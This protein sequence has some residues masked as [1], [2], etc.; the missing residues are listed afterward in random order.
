LVDAFGHHFN[1]GGLAGFP[2]AGVTGFG[3]MAHPIPDDCFDCIRS[4][5]WN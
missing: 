3:A 4:S 2:F 1:L 5:R